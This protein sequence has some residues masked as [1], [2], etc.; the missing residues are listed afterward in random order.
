MA[1]T[2]NIGRAKPWR[3]FRRTT[4]RNA[5]FCRHGEAGAF[6]VERHDDGVPKKELTDSAIPRPVRHLLR[7]NRL[8]SIAIYLYKFP[9]RNAGQFHFSHGCT[10]AMKVLWIIHG[11]E[12]YGEKRAIR[13]LMKGVQDSGWQAEAAALTTGECADA[14]THDGLHVIPLNV[15]DSPGLH[16]ARHRIGKLWQLFLLF[17][18]QLRLPRCAARSA[19]AARMSCTSSTRTS[20]PRS[21]GPLVAK[22][23]PASGK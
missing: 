18:H 1:A 13:S 17:G 8:S 12:T 2:L 23:N 21:P 15:G 14:I 7:A 5:P 9:T 10:H 20:F 16:Q 11:G 6:L 19:P 3:R 22:A 4:I